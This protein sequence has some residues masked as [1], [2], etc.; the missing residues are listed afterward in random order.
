M[1]TTRLVCV[2]E[3]FHAKKIDFSLNDSTKRTFPLLDA[4]HIYDS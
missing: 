3:L 2:N 1:M 4:S